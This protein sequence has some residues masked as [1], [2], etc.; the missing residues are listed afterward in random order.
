M[1]DLEH[2]LIDDMELYQEE[3]NL[4]E[5]KRREESQAASVNQ[6]KLELSK[7]EFWLEQIKTDLERSQSKL[8]QIQ[9]DLERS[10]SNPTQEKFNPSQYQPLQQEKSKKLLLY[11]DDFGLGGV[12]S[13][14]HSL[15]CGL[16]LLG[17]SIT[18]VQ[19][20][21]DNSKVSYQKRVGIQHYWI[22]YDTAREF[23]RTLTDQSDAEK[24]FKNSRP[25]LVIFSNCSPLSNF[26]A[27]QVANKLNIPYILV[28]GLVESPL[29]DWYAPYFDELSRHYKQAH[30]VIS[31]SHNNLTILRDQLN[32]PENKG[33]VIYYGRPPEYF[34]PQ[35]ADVRDRLRH[36]FNIPTDAVVCFTAS[37]IETRKGH[38][39]QIAAIKQLMQ[40]PLWPKLFFIWAGACVFQPEFEAQLKKEIN[41]LGVTDKVKFLGD[42]SDII[43]W[44]DATDIF[45][46]PSESEGMPLCVMEA[47]AKGLPV[48]ATSVS[49]I[50]EELGDTGKLL[51][52]P[53]IDPEA[54]IRE[55]FTTIESFAASPELRKQIGQAC[56][57]RAEQMFREKRM[58][59]ETLEVIEQALLAAKPPIKSKLSVKHT[60]PL[61]AIDGMFFQGHNSGIARVWKTLLE[62]W[63][64]NGFAKHLIVFDRIGTAPK[65]PEIR[66]RVIPIHDYNAT[67]TDRQILQEVC[68]Q[69]GVDLFISTYY[70][71]PLSTPS[72]FMAYDMIPEFFGWNLNLPEWR[73]KHYGIQHACAYIAISENTARNLIGCFPHIP[74]DSVTVAHC[75]VNSNFVPSKPEKISTFKL[76]Y[77][78]SKPYFLLVG[79]R[80][81]YKN[82]AFFLKAYYQLTNKS[83]F[84]IICIGGDSVLEPEFTHYA[85]NRT[86]HLQ[87]ISDDELKEAYS[88]A[89]ALIY[90]SLYEGFGM[91][92]IEAMAC[93]CPVI[94]CFCGSIPEVAGQAALYVKEFDVEDF[95]KLLVKVQQP[96]VR[97]SLITAGLEQAKKFT[98]Q[99]MAEKISLVLLDL[100]KDDSQLKNYDVQSINEMQLS[101]CWLKQHPEDLQQWYKDTADHLRTKYDLNQFSIVFDL[102]G[103]EG[104]WTGSIYEKFGCWVY[105]FEPI[106]EFAK[107]IRNKFLQVPKISVYPFGLAGKTEK[108][109]ISVQANESSLFKTGGQNAQ[110]IDIVKA[111]DFF[112]EHEIQ[113]IDLMK[114]NIEGGEYDLLDHLI[115]S[116][117]VSNIKNLQVQFHDFVDDAGLRMY[118]IQRKLIKT[119]KLT[120]QYPFVWENWQIR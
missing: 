11:T 27:K 58:I 21:V 74:P 81:A 36:Y 70:T 17:Y 65:I 54:T 25:D 38:H 4:R 13:Y 59:E 31:V 72:V 104:E 109:L 106:K 33:Q 46:L 116:G 92:I 78:I 41:D 26:A 90:P 28:E 24:V 53:K 48:I 1:K 64:T 66:Y 37:R 55:L 3:L 107:N 20:K 23:P 62:E 49:G 79:W 7:K 97:Q 5:E 110:E 18:L 22:E 120:W 86:I 30:R 34:T 19:S 101:Q 84:D 118:E 61:I 39:Y 114:I 8:Q 6:H 102:G 45:I 35:K 95:V 115:D 47:M 113:V 15:V 117:F 88:G 87:R 112:Y 80:T 99:K 100:A 32:L 44:L 16:A 12:S 42:R 67:D 94:T 111:I 93:G 63:A 119:H 75:G 29:P 83:D 105:V 2:I 71:T 91:P 56:K 89:V 69:E 85:Q 103:Y 14:N 43:D 82:T 68:D 57:K 76:K 52:D 51:P 96:E 50:P 60:Y 40:S 10:R 108:M 9:A 73:E 98:W 77:G